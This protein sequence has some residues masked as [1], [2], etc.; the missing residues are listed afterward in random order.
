MN[1]RDAEGAEKANDENP[2]AT[3][4]TRQNQALTIAHSLKAGHETGA[5][6]MTS[7]LGTACRAL[8]CGLLDFPSSGAIRDAFAVGSATESER[9]AS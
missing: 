5:A 4:A 7:L 2:A 1:R 3:A 9:F 6:S 8:P